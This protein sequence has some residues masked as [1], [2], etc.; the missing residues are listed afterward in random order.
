MQNHAEVSLSPMSGS[1]FIPDGSGNVLVRFAKGAERAL[2]HHFKNFI[3]QKLEPGALVADAA[4]VTANRGP[5]V[6]Q[7]VR[8]QMA[9][10]A[11]NRA[12]LKLTPEQLAPSE[13]AALDALTE[14]MLVDAYESGYAAG[15]LDT[16]I[17]ETSPELP[18]EETPR[19]SAEATGTNEDGT[20]SFDAPE[21][22]APHIPM[23]T[24]R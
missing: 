24:S 21:T 3:A 14:G 1:A 17:I 8:R 6:V 19:E 5:A 2:V 16:S 10:L 12:G 7:E 9:I 13:E 11:A 22:P 18:E 23:F 4:L 20:P 15:R